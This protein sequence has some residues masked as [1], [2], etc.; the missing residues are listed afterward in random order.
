[1]ILAV[2]TVLYK[3]IFVMLS[4]ILLLLICSLISTKH[5]FF[6]IFYHIG[7]FFTYLFELFNAHS[8]CFSSR[9]LHVTLTVVLLL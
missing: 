6:N 2:T 5:K 9:T 8:L 1:M 4:F 3:Y 7:L